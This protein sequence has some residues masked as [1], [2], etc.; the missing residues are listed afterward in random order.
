MIINPQTV[1]ISFGTTELRGDIFG[2]PELIVLHGAGKS[3]SRRNFRAL[4]LSLFEQGVGS[5]ALDFIGHGETGGQLIGS[6]L[7]SRTAQSL[8]FIKNLPV[9]ESFALLGSSMSAYTAI[10]LTEFLTISSLIL[11]VPAMY[12]RAAYSASFGP[13]FSAIIRKT[14]S[15]ENSDGWEILQKFSG[16]LLVITAE[17]DEVIPIAIIEKI[18]RCATSAAS[19]QHKMIE[20]SSHKGLFDNNLKARQCVAEMIATLVH[21]QRA[22]MR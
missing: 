18:I 16:H 8:R 5:A 15:W 19:V 1:A 13:E 21:Q 22:S 9:E 12:D 4:R 10:R 20:G 6:S 3:A 11:I 7:E 17:F 14:A 2:H